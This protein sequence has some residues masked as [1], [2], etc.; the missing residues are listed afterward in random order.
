MKYFLIVYDTRTAQL[1]EVQ[2]FEGTEAALAARFAREQQHD[3]ESSV[4]VVLLRAESE[5]AL[6]DS[7]A[8]YFSSLRQLVERSQAAEPARG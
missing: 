8:R 3:A 1:Q 5:E 2:A 7:H 4:E 6:H